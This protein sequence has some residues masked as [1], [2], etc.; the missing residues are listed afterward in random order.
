MNLIVA[1]FLFLIV[2]FFKVYIMLRIRVIPMN[3]FNI[4]KVACPTS[5]KKG[6]TLILHNLMGISLLCLSSLLCIYFVF[7]TMIKC[8]IS[9]IELRIESR[10][11]TSTI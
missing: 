2:A 4:F 6:K 5:D 8:L 10:I 7:V 9:P 1:F 11:E 3:D